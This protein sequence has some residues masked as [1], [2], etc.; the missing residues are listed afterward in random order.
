[1]YFIA[2]NGRVY[3][4]NYENKNIPRLAIEN[5]HFEDKEEAWLLAH[6]LEET[7]PRMFY[8]K[9]TSKD[10]LR[11]YASGDTETTYRKRT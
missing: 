5:N 6:E 2:T 1:M 10:G 7:H 8:G 11:L 4:D 9:P 3:R